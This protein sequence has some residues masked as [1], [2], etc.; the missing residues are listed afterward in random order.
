MPSF[1]LPIAFIESLGGPEMVMIF[2]IVL[3]LFGGKKLPEF[4]RG[5]G[6]SIREFKKAAAGVEEE[7]KRALEEDEQKTA[8]AARALESPPS[9]TPA[10]GTPATDEQ[11]TYQ[12]Y[13]DGYGHDEYHPHSQGDAGEQGW[14][15]H[16]HA[17][18][19]PGSPAATAE[20]TPAPPAESPAAAPSPD[21]G[22]P[23]KPLP[24]TPAAA[25]T[26][27]D[28]ASPPPPAAPPAPEPEK[29]P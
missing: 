16:G 20:T 9:P 13:T 23:E 29:K 11:Q 4:A 22:T 2:V 10:P 8:A 26:P 5:M 7:F 6:K 28:P 17:E 25:G 3:V 27:G 15:E 1:C 19:T 21:M 14:N 12:P 24:E 18:S